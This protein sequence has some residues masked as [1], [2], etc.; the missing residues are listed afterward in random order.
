M[1]KSTETSTSTE[2][3]DGTVS[4]RW[5]YD[6]TITLGHLLIMFGIVTS[7]ISLYTATVV[8]LSSHEAR[9]TVLEK[10]A[11]VQS[12]YNKSALEILN[13]L[14]IGTAITDAVNR[15]RERRQGQSRERVEDIQEKVS[16]KDKEDADDK[17]RKQDKKALQDGAEKA[18][19]QREEL[20][21]D[22][23]KRNKETK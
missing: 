21:G 23:K 10:L 20:M 4:N 6:G 14:K 19:K 17:E 9:I 15:D 16:P 3:K 13:E 12:Q 1:P 7:G 8:K 18:I 5:R 2:V 22:M 11:E